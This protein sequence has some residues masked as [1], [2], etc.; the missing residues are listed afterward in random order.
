[1]K[2]LSFKLPNEKRSLLTLVEDTIFLLLNVS[3]CPGL[4][5]CPRLWKKKYVKHVCRKHQHGRK[6]NDFQIYPCPFQVYFWHKSKSKSLVCTCEKA[7][8]DNVRNAGH[9]PG[10]ERSCR[11]VN[12]H[13]ALQENC[14]HT[15]NYLSKWVFKII[16]V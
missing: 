13:G 9:Q 3:S 1:M 15:K 11:I 16:F 7:F 2:S 10:K 4:S 6:C 12:F 14:S 5:S 8:L